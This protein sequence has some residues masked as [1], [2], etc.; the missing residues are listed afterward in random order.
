MKFVKY[1][2]ANIKKKLCSSDKKTTYHYLNMLLAPSIETQENTC[3]IFFKSLWKCCQRFYRSNTQDLSSFK[4]ENVICD[5]VYLVIF[6]HLICLMS[7]NHCLLNIGNNPVSQNM[8]CLFRT[9]IQKLKCQTKTNVQ[10]AT[11]MLSLVFV[12]C[13]SSQL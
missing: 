9:T 1:R 4:Q 11:T 12:Q 6:N 10:Q 5:V 8:F 2:G 7:D 13:V 3:L